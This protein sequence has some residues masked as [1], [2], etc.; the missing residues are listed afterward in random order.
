[1][2]FKKKLRTTA[3]KFYLNRFRQCSYF[4]SPGTLENQRFFL[5]FLGSIKCEYWNP[6]KQMKR[7]PKIVKSFYSLTKFAKHSIWEFDRVLNTPLQVVFFKINPCPPPSIWRTN[8]SKNFSILQ[9][10]VH[11]SEYGDD[12]A[13]LWF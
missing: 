6:V 1:M 2:I 4:I 3:S 8:F 11:M 9:V 7:F 13:I 10:R 12:N 5:V